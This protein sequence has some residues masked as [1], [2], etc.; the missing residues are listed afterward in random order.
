MSG[1]A[2]KEVDDSTFDVHLT[3]SLYVFRVLEATI[4]ESSNEF[5]S[6]NR[7]PARK[8]RGK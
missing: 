1:G 7:H 2:W 5:V 8:A 4:Y 6:F 3:N